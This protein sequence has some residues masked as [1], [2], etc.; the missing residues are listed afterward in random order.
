MTIEYR[1]DNS[2]LPY[3]SVRLQGND[4][5]N[6]GFPGIARTGE[7]GIASVRIDDPTGTLDI[8]G[9][10]TFTVDETACSKPNIFAGWI[11]GRTDGRGP[12]RT[13]AGR[14]W[15]CEIIDQNAIF[16]LEV[17]R[18]HAD[19]ARPAETDVA[20]VQAIITSGAMSGTPIHDNGRFS[21]ANPINLGAANFVGQYADEAMASTMGVAGKNYYAYF[22]DATRQI[23]LHYDQFLTGPAAG[24]SI[25]NVKSDVTS[26]SGGTV[27]APMIDA[28]WNSD[29]ERLATG[30]LLHY[31]NGYVYARNQALIDSL[32]PTI[33]SPVEFRR[34]FSY[35]SDRIGNPTTANKYMHIELDR[36]STEEVTLTCT[37][38]VSRTHVNLVR[39]GDLI[40]VRFS[41]LPGFETTT[42]VIVNRRLVSPTDDQDLYYDVYLEMGVIGA[43]Q[44]PGG[45]DP[46]V[47]PTPSC[48]PQLVQDYQTN[49]S[50]DLFVANGVDLTTTPTEGN[51]L[52]AWMETR[53]VRFTKPVPT[54]WTATGTDWQ[55]DA[56]T[57]GGHKEIGCRFFYKWVTS[58]DTTHIAFTSGGSDNVFIDV[59][60]WSGLDTFIEHTVWTSS[61]NVSSPTPYIMATADLHPTVGAPTLEIAGFMPSLNT[62]DLWIPNGINGT[63]DL[64]KPGYGN[65]GVNAKGYVGY[66]A[67]PSAV[68]T[69]YAPLLYCKGDPNSGIMRGFAVLAL[70]FSGTCGDNNQPVPG[71]PVGPE[72][73]SVGGGQQQFTTDFP[74]APNSLMV[75]VDG[76]LQPA[77]ETDPGTGAY[78]LLFDPYPDEYVRVYYQAAT[79][80][81]AT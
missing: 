24:I 12:Y 32:S 45:G 68:A 21:T 64:A 57:G 3:Q 76:I 81:D 70:T 41:H 80:T 69:N 56:A 8:D 18:S 65:S 4:G 66:S 26:D 77:E 31:N 72:Q 2:L 15:D 39:P 61:E 40:N 29:P 44:A 48:S 36:R 60:E 11:L 22:D 79:G 9:W 55:D 73:P 33:F 23:S 13:G 30:V 75:F 10:H 1:L 37:I 27:Y 47:F 58:T 50:G 19:S 67:G 35:Q 53:D 6:N 14:V 25:S 71:Q 78:T 7:P 62:N 52:I 46:G 51:V 43:A 16:H 17:F 42:Q 74:Y 5:T 20:R 59:S 54:G 49:Q 38:Q 63:H 28:E 34:D